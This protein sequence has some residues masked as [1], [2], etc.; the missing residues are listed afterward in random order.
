MSKSHEK[1]TGIPAEEVLRDPTVAYNLIL[2]E[3]R[4]Q[5]AKAEEVAIPDKIIFDQELRFRRAD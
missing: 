5:L 1:L 3:D 2:P 4:E